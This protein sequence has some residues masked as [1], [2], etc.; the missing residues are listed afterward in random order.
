MTIG[1]RCVNMNLTLLVATF[2]FA[3][4]TGVSTEFKHRA[5]HLTIPAIPQQT[6]ECLKAVDVIMTRGTFPW[7]PHHMVAIADGQVRFFNLFVGT[8][9]PIGGDI[10]K[11]FPFGRNTMKQGYRQVNTTITLVNGVNDAYI[12]TPLKDLKT[13]TVKHI[14]RYQPDH[15]YVGYPKTH[16]IGIDTNVGAVYAG[17]HNRNSEDLFLFNDFGNGTISTIHWWRNLDEPTW[18]T[19]NRPHIRQKEPGEKMWTT[20]A[21]FDEMDQYILIGDREFYAFVPRQ[22]LAKRYQS[23]EEINMTLPYPK[24]PWAPVC[25]IIRAPVI[26]S[27]KPP[28][29]Q[30]PPTLESSI[31]K[32]KELS[33]PVIPVVIGVVVLI[34]LGTLIALFVSTKKKREVDLP[35]D[36]EIP[37]GGLRS[38]LLLSKPL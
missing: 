10:D 28:V 22:D 9:D 30:T 2:L 15:F 5:V 36:N 35:E 23:P 7:Y 8:L 21:Y 18:K 3:T 11:F 13:F 32:K 34:I 26:P 6:K 17:P 24:I 31:H 27:T 14:G 33:F 38:E 12:Y 29:V 16:G 37:S 19:W 1:S 25:K 20:A 4:A